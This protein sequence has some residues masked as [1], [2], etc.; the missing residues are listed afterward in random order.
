VY[1]GTSDFALVEFMKE[2]IAQGV[3]T[4]KVTWLCGVACYTRR[5]LTDGASAVEGSY[6]WIPF[7]PLEET[8]TTP[9]LA[10]YVDTIGKAKVD[11]WGVVSWQSAIA[12]Q[13]VVNKIVADSG[14]NAITRAK[15]LAGLEALKDFDADG[16]S[17]PH[18]LGTT[19]PCYVLMQVKG[20]KFVRSWPTKAG[21]LDC[22]ADNL[23]TVNVNPEKQAA[24][25]LS[26]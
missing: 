2:A 26:S 7:I 12:F 8:S 9:A 16:I 18:A 5:F 1:G 4:S 25:D 19:S 23:Q 14:P 13:Q 6:V 22:K 20:G 3:D 17:G 24:T 11:T 21:T 10:A 15:V